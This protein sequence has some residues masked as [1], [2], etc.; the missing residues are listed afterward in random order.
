MS[1]DSLYRSY[2]CASASAN[3]IGNVEDAYRD[4]LGR[5]RIRELGF[6]RSVRALF[7]QRWTLESPALAGVSAEFRRQ[8]EANHDAGQAILSILDRLGIAEADWPAVLRAE[9]LALPGWPGLMRRLEAEPEL[10]PHVNLPC[11]LADYVAVRL[12]LAAAAKTNLA[13]EK[14]TCEPAA[15]AE[16]WRLAAAARLYETAMDY[17][18]IDDAHG[19]ALCPVVLLTLLIAPARD[20]TP[21][22]IAAMLLIG[23]GT[24]ATHSGL[25]L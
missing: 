13:A 17:K 23:A 9:L 25:Q 6:Y 22:S 15:D 10:A 24:L 5:G 1:V 4:E 14:E 21:G 18:G 3:D 12:T 8:A 16:T 19:V 11:S 2:A 7:A 20:R